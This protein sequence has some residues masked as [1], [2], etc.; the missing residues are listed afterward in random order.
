MA[1]Y[2]VLIFGD[3]AEWEAMGSE[4]EAKI[5]EAHQAFTARA[6]TAILAA[7]Q[8]EPSQTSTSLRV[9]GAGQVAITD[10]PFLEAKEGLGGFYLLE[11]DDLDQVISLASGLYEVHAGHSGVE[12][13]PLVDHG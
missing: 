13:R 6:G 1:K 10:G 2:M 5:D 9:D 8:L 3:E 11:A 7:G 12:I 4:E